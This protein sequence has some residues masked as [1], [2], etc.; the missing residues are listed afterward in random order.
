MDCVGTGTTKGGTIG[1]VGRL[2]EIADAF[3]V[4]E[5]GILLD[6]AA[7]FFMVVVVV[8][9]FFTVLVGSFLGTVVVLEFLNRSSSSTAGALLLISIHSGVAV[10]ESA[11]NAMEERMAK[12]N[13]LISL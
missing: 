9:G 2:E 12:G 10:V 4:D 7:G 6:D 11:M 1:D 8:T 5:T 3:I 13:K